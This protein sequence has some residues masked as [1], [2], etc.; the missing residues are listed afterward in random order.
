MVRYGY[1]PCETCAKALSCQMRTQFNINGCLD[2]V[3]EIVVNT[4]SNTTNPSTPVSVQ[5]LSPL[6]Q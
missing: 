5:E 6:E 3:E 4:V 1:G 2:H